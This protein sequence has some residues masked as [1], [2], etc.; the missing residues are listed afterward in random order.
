M[1]MAIVKVLVAWLGGLVAGGAL[2]A[3][4]DPTLGQVVQLILGLALLAWACPFITDPE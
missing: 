3:F 1:T 4:P 2:D